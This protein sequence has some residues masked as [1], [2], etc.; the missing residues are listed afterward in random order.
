MVKAKEK[1]CSILGFDS[2]LIEGD[3]T[4]LFMKMHNPDYVI[5]QQA[6]AALVDSLNSGKV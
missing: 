1:L 6:V 3:G 5:R 2:S 4:T